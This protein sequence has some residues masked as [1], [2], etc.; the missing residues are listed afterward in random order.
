MKKVLLRWSP[1]Q[2][3]VE[4]MKCFD[5]AVGIKTFIVSDLDAE[6]MQRSVCNRKCRHVQWRAT[7]RGPHL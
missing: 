4:T 7:Q 3:L 6:Q 1:L 5:A 2:S